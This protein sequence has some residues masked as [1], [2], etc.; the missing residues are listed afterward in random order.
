MSGQ[1]DNYAS[2]RS[3]ARYVR[4][5]RDKVFVVKLGGDMLSDARARRN[6]CEQLALLWNFS[7]P[8]VVVHGGGAELDATCEAMGIEVKKIAGRRVTGKPVLDAAKM[9]FSKLQ[10]DLLADMRAA[11]L[12]CVGMSG[13]DG[14]VLHAE[15][16]KQSDVDFGW[17]GDLTSVNPPLLSH[18]IKG[19]YVPVLAPL[20]ANDQGEVFN[21]N[22]DTIAAEVAAALSAEKL[23]FLL[24]VPGLLEDAA[25]PS[26]L[27]N[28]ADLKLLGAMEKT[29]KLKD[30]MLPKAAAVKLALAKGVKS[31]HLV[32]G[33]D[34]NAL[35]TEVFT[36]AGSGTMIVAESGS[37]AEAVA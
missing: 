6:I 5:F 37:Q 7:I 23:F 1:S 12:P 19:G 9:V 29:G 4:L 13:V 8:L 10:T 36:N 26:T 31:I 17:V 28:Y 18:L 20:S 32:S 34:S 21:T 27:V 14:G 33:V 22:A 24:K 25:N 35:L 11:G 3:A 30:G 16:R 2:L 15:K